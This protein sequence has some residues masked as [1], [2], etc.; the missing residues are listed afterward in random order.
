MKLKAV[1]AEAE[2]KPTKG[3]NQQILTGLRK[4]RK[5]HATSY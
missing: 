4:I 5:A 2:T 1:E 3:I